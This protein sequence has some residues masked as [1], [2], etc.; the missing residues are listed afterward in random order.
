MVLGGLI[1]VGC[2]SYVILVCYLVVCGFCFD[3]MTS[4]F[5]VGYCFEFVLVMH[6]RDSLDV[7]WVWGVV[8]WFSVGACGFG[9]ERFLV[10]LF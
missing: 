4:R 3:L 10:V 7:M 5:A 1:V 2:L 8:S 9:A 6:L